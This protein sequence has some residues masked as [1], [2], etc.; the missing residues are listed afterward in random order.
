MI[1]E[2]FG[3]YWLIDAAAARAL[4]ITF[5]R[6]Y[7]GRF[8]EVVAA[9]EALS[10]VPPHALVVDYGADVKG[11]RI[12]S[13]LSRSRMPSG[14]PSIDEVGEA[15]R[16][17]AA[18]ARDG[19]VLEWDSPGGALL[20]LEKNTQLLREV[21]QETT[22]VNWV[23]SRMHSA[24]YYLASGSSGEIIASPGSSV[25]SIG[26]LTEI[27]EQPSERLQK[28]IQEFQLKTHTVVSGEEEDSEKSIGRPGVPFSPAQ[29][30]AVKRQVD[31]IALQFHRTVA[32]GRSLDLQAVQALPHGRTW[33]PEEALELGL[34]DAVGPLS[35]A[36]ARVREL[37]AEKRRRTFAMSDPKT[38]AEDPTPTPEPS[39]PEPT[40]PPVGERFELTSEMEAL[41]QS[42]VP[43]TY[44]MAMRAQLRE[45]NSAAREQLLAEL[46]QTPSF[47]WLR[48]AATQAASTAT[49]QLQDDQRL[50][51]SMKEAG[52]EE[53]LESLHLLEAL[54]LEGAGGDL[55]LQTKSGKSLYQAASDV[56]GSSWKHGLSEPLPLSEDGDDVP[57]AAGSALKPELLKTVRGKYAAHYGKN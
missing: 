9:S 10:P 48:D 1:D 5:L 21:A 19:V 13:V 56:L 11:V 39:S 29:R 32:E 49:R 27:D 33:G 28:G 16:A 26:V 35:M 6:E 2:F 40:K 53:L 12:R 17:A 44:R 20:G 37:A 51:P 36:V 46:Q 57:V 15:I 24:A 22:V 45:S 50:T 34:I 43:A 3:S 52:A 7:G 8:S 31:A 41:L 55:P 4:R 30:A 38:V 14:P 25:G 54:R 18:E 42:R 47:P 23:D